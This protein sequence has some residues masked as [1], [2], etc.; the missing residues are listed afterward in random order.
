MLVSR[1]TTYRIA[2]RLF[3]VIG[4]GIG[5]NQDL[6][7]SLSRV[8]LLRD[9]SDEVIKSL[10]KRS[11]WRRFAR[12]EQI[13][14]RDSD[15]RDV[16]L[17]V[18]GS[19]EVINYSL[20]GREVAF[21]H[22]PEGGYFGELSAIDGGRRSANIVVV[23]DSLVLVVP[24]DVFTEILT[25]ARTVSFSAVCA[26]SIDSG[27]IRKASL[28]AM[29]RSVATLTVKPLLVLADGRDVPPGLPCLGRAVVKGDQRSQSIAAA[30]IVAK[31]MRDRMMARAGA[32][33]MRY[34]FE[35]HMG[36]A[37]VRHRTARARRGLQGPRGAGRVLVRPGRGHRP[38]RRRRR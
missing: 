11:H 21:G 33:D 4:N 38:G 17:V 37:T 19:V 32:C 3:A 36:Y 35:V 2:R 16:F 12:G 10:E 8:R 18:K 27:D 28:E 26:G 1:T 22:V 14:D 20:S 7:E 15:S 34:G 9:L 6:T 25:R 30:S 5:V 24:P 31:V 13:L 23:E 29:R